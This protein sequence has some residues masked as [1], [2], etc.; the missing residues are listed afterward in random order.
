[1]N[2]RLDNVEFEIDEGS[3]TTDALHVK[4]EGD[5]ESRTYLFA[6]TG[7]GRVWVGNMSAAMNSENSL[8]YSRGAR[9]L[10]KKNIFVQGNVRFP[11]NYVY[12]VNVGGH[13]V[14]SSLSKADLLHADYES[15]TGFVYR[16]QRSIGIVPEAIASGTDTTGGQ[17]FGVAAG[18]LSIERFDNGDIRFSNN[19]NELDTIHTGSG[20]RVAY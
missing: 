15:N 6:L 8:L 19:D 16:A 17:W 18:Y 1:M 2:V 4:G 5:T 7:D 20:R 13:V 10:N 14:L 12:R 11:G 3:L 9:E